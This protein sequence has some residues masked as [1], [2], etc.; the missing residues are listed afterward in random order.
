MS[1]E[2]TVEY[3]AHPD[4]AV[5]TCEAAGYTPKTPGELMVVCG[6]HGGVLIA[7]MTRQAAETIALALQWDDDHWQAHRAK[8]DAPHAD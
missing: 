3:G 2:M 8:G 5:L 4:Y 1:D 6:R 7:T